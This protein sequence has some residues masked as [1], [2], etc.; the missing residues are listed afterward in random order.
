MNGA[1]GLGKMMS[2]INADI[3][4]SRRTLLECID[5][6]RSYRTRSGHEVEMDPQEIEYLSTVC[7]Q[8]DRMYLR[9]PILITT[10]VAGEGT[11][12]KVDGRI[13]S[14]I[15]SKVLGR[16][17]HDGDKMRIYHSDYRMLLKKMPTTTAIIY[18]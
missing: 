11:C 6:D 2:D 17:W 8:I 16:E 15:I 7:D 12:W 3:P 13:E 4:V 9:L 18:I 10:D 1:Q 14:K 5:G